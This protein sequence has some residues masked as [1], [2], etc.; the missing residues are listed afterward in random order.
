MVGGV[1]GANQVL[2]GPAIQV[3][4][5]ATDAPV[6]CIA[7]LALALVHGVTEVAQVDA[8]RVP[9][10]AVGLVLARVFRLAHLWAKGHTPVTLRLL[11]HGKGPFRVLC[12]QPPGQCLELRH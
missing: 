3:R 2:V 10:A 1:G 6:A 5:L 8:L 11:L 12:L 7:C 4:V 9:V